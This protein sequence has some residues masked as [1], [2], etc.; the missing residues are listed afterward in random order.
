[1]S[2]AGVPMGTIW[3]EVPG[4]L[5]YVSCGLY[6]CWGANRHN[7]VYFRTG[8]KA[9]NPIGTKWLRISDVDLTQIE[10]G[11][12]GLPMIIDIAETTSRRPL[13]C[14]L[15][16]ALGY[17]SNVHFCHRYLQCGLMFL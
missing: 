1:M 13:S 9:N 10:S 4:R 11:P 12:G 2:R 3:R 8:V 7:H 16:S 6:G 17:R 14:P 5:K 15:S